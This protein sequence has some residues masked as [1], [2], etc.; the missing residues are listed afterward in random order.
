[1]TKFGLIN[2]IILSMV[3]GVVL[4]MFTC[5]PGQAQLPISYY[6]TQPLNFIIN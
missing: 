3:I 5:I 4:V 6:Y 1:M 2:K